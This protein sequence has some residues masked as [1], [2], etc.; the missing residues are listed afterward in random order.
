MRRRKNQMQSASIL[1]NVGQS[2][3]AAFE[4]STI[5][6][7]TNSNPLQ[8]QQRT[9]HQT[10]R[11]MQNGS[12]IQYEYRQTL[13]FDAMGSRRNESPIMPM[14]QMISANAFSN[15]TQET[16]GCD[17]GQSQNYHRNSRY[18]NASDSGRAS[19]KIIQYRGASG[20]DMSE[21]TDTRMEDLQQ[22]P[23]CVSTEE[24]ERSSNRRSTFSFID[25]EEEDNMIPKSPPSRP[26]RSSRKLRRSTS[27]RSLS[28]NDNA[29]N[30]EL[31]LPS[32]NASRMS[33]GDSSSKEEFEQR[34]IQFLNQMESLNKLDTDNPVMMRAFLTRP[35]PKSVGMM[36]CYIKRN[37]GIKNKLF[38]EYRVYL[39]ETNAFLMT[40]K[41]RIGNATSNY[42]ISMGRN[43]FDNRLSP[44]VLGK[45]RSNFLGTEYTI[46]DG[47]RNP[48]YENSCDDNADG[49][50]RCEL[51]AILYAAS[52][53]LG[54]KGPRKMKACIGKVDEDNSATK[55]WQ[56]MNE[57]DDRMVTC[58]KDN[59]SS[60][61]NNLM[62]FV[63]KNPGWNGEIKA[64]SLNFNGRVTLAS[65]K[66]F[67]LIDESNPEKI[68]LQFGRTGKDEFIF[69]FQWPLSPLQ[70]FAFALSSFDSKLGCD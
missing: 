3:I 24:D 66:N 20:D 70:A 23:R 4:N 9:F 28:F 44:N 56:P 54:A 59:S 45:L 57:D 42:L 16:I 15:Q 19:Q 51:G 34:T 58:F 13:G 36:K 11:I 69:D 46:Y 12:S 29:E 63:N 18:S 7:N 39:K 67:Q 52:T 55:I 53:T 27:T 10:N 50:V 49:N 38:P 30:D 25:I 35:C 17:N 64:Y 61:N 26:D 22:P 14:T 32:S 65:V 47:G 2:N 33:I 43:D 68:Y 31:L 8:Y 21:L 1:P 62:S 41:K 40:S 6:M 60:Q 37:K 5:K 48:H